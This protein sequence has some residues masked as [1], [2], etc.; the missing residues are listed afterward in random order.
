MSRDG[1]HESSLGD[2]ARSPSS[3]PA[4]WEW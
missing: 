1:G 4:S 3:L 2:G